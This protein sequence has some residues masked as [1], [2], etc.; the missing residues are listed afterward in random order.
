MSWA[1]LLA[2]SSVVLAL[3]LACSSE[4]ANKN[5]NW[6][7]KCSSSAE[8]GEAS[9]ICEMCTKPCSA[10][11]SCAANAG[12]CSDSFAATTQCSGQASAGMC[13]A[14]CSQESDCDASRT[15]VAG[16]C[17]A[18]G[19]GRCAAH[20]NALACSGFEAAAEA[21]WTPSLRPGGALEIAAAPRF[22][23]IGA[24]LARTAGANGRSRLSHEFT[25]VDS[26]QLFLRAWMYAA[27]GTVL[28]D[29]HTIVIGDV[30]TGDYGSKF[31]YSNGMLHVA[32]SGSAVDGSVQPALGEWHCLRMELDIG[33]VGSI[34]A[35]VDDVK[36]VDAA[37][38]DT[39]PAAGVHNIAVGID[40]AGQA[41]PAE[42]VTDELVLDTNP[43]GCWD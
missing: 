41:E 25:R 20:T 43:V 13:M 34:R 24:L 39:L 10:A 26:G 32:S 15:C 36:F 23:G 42:V 16:A 33:A 8:C 28:N 9:C 1:A 6:L 30:N 22:A 14:T 17:V 21:S 3:P 29:V 31:L 27:P 18:R 2:I 4:T 11:D 12:V 40:F 5:T 19:D 35:F 38:V 37:G 7:V